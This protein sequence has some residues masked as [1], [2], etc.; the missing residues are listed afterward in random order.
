MADVP[1]TANDPYRVYPQAE[2][3][4]YACHTCGVSSLV[5][6]SVCG[7]PWQV[8]CSNG[9]PWVIRVGQDVTLRIPSET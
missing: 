1:P 9:H 5:V 6:R 4:S 3:L 8:S 7:G 2:E